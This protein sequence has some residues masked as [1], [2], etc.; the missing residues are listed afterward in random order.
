MRLKDVAVGLFSILVT[1][2]E[3]LSLLEVPTLNGSR[4][5]KSIKEQVVEEK[6]PNDL[7][8]NNL[9]RLCV[10]ETPSTPSLYTVIEKS[11]VEIDIYVTKEKNAIDRRTLL[12][13]DRIFNLLHNREIDGFQIHYFNRLP[14]LATDN[15]SWSKYGL[16]FSYD[17]III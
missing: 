2:S 16:V 10:Y 11:F 8:V 9:S 17:N 4:T 3:L 15:N 6:Y 1:D 12:I 5:M 13:V 14:N 7:V